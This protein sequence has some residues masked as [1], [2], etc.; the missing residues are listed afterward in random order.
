[1][2]GLWTFA[3]WTGDFAGFHA[4]RVSIVSGFL[5]LPDG[6]YNFEEGQQ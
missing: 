4:R 1:L 2:L 6:T 5:F 3:D